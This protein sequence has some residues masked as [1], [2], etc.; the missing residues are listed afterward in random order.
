MGQKRGY[1]SNLKRQNFV[2]SG[3][4]QRIRRKGIAYLGE[5][6]SILKRGHEKG[7]NPYLIRGSQDNLRV[8]VSS[9]LQLTSANRVFTSVACCFLQSA[10]RV[11]SGSHWDERGAGGLNPTLLETCRKMRTVTLYGRFY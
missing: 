10:R 8:I 4:Y 1:L 3:S 9:D 5:C 11:P 6:A 2:K 7:D